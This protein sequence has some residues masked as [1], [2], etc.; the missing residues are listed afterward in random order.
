[1]VKNMRLTLSLSLTL[2]VMHAMVTDRSTTG[3]MISLMARS[4]AIGTTRLSAGW[5]LKRASSELVLTYAPRLGITVWSGAKEVAEL[6]LGL[7]AGLEAEL[8]ATGADAD[9]A[10]PA[11][12]AR[13]EG[14][15]ELR[16]EV[17]AEAALDD[18]DEWLGG[19]FWTLKS[20]FCAKRN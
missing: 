4:T 10:S 3:W 19:F 9:L 16:L 12:L 6:G 2:L 8:D 14:S 7:E 20:G 1:M 18:E 5:L 11:F 13:L 15:R 17:E